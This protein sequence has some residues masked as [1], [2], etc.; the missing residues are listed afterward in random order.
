MKDVPL[1]TIWKLIQIASLVQVVNASIDIVLWI[2][3]GTAVPAWA[4]ALSIIWYTVLL[5]AL[6][7]AVADEQRKFCKLERQP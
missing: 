6:Y 2:T 1:K 3:R 5:F 7:Q 4:L